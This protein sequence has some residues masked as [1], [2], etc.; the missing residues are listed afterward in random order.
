MATRRGQ[1]LWAPI[2]SMVLGLVALC[3]SATTPSVRGDGLRLQNPADVELA[4]VATAVEAWKRAEPR[5]PSGASAREVDDLRRM[6][7]EHLR[8]H[9][10]DVEALVLHARMGRLLH[11]RRLRE[12][13]HEGTAAP[14]DSLDQI[15]AELDRALSREPGNA[16]AHYWEART[17]GSRRVEFRD[18]RRAQP[19]VDLK[20]AVRLAARAVEL[21]PDRSPYRELVAWYLD[22]SGRPDEAKAT[23]AADTSLRIPALLLEDWTCKLPR[24]RYSCPK[25]PSGWAN[26]SSR[27]ARSPIPPPVQGPRRSVSRSGLGRRGLVSAAVASIPTVP[28]GAKRFATGHSQ[29]DAVHRRRHRPGADKPVWPGVPRR[30]KA[31]GPRIAGVALW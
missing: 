14:P 8:S 19:Y 13:L 17:C 3:A 10:D 15:L 23:L 6:L 27:A 31:S 24:G 18:G 1:R 2:T 28:R 30:R 29:G 22:A 25:R 26:S 9:P 5:L 20:E 7:G 16:A 12:A 21:A 11:A 4:Q